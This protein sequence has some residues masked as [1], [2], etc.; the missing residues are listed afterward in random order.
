MAIGEPAPAHAQ[1]VRW[2][3]SGGDVAYPTNFTTLMAPKF[4]NEMAN[5]KFIRT[6][7]AS[8]T[9]DGYLSSNDWS[10]FNAKQAT[11]GYTPATNTLAGILAAMGYTPPTNNNA[12][13]VLALSFSPATNTFAGIA[14]ALG[15]TP[16]T[17]TSAG[18]VSAL[19]FQPATNTLAGILAAMGYTPPTNNNSGIVLALGFNPATNSLAGIAAALGYT[20]MTNTAAAITAALGYTP[21]PGNTTLSNLFNTGAFTNAL[22]AGSGVTF[23]TNASGIITISAAAGSGG[24]ADS[25]NPNPQLNGLWQQRLGASYWMVASTNNNGNMQILGPSHMRFDPLVGGGLRLGGTFGVFANSMTVSNNLILQGTVTGTAA[26]PE[27]ALSLSDNTTGNASTVKH[28]FAPKLSGSVVDVLSGLGTWVKGKMYHTNGQVAVS[29]DNE[30]QGIDLKDETG[31]TAMFVSEGLRLLYDDNGSPSIDFAQGR[32]LYETP[33]GIR[34]DWINRSLGGTWTVNALNVSGA[35][36]A[37]SIATPSLVATNFSVHTLE[38]A[39]NLF[40][41]TL[42]QLGRSSTITTSTNIGL[43]GLSNLPTGSNTA[44]GILNIRSA[45]P[46]VTLTNPPGWGPSD[47]VRTRSI[48][49]GVVCVEVQPGV[50]TNMVILH[51]PTL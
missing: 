37:D 27:V 24:A 28:G 12:G 25:I 26:I 4:A 43:T 30:D 9:V 19:K 41:G 46:G 15:Y 50:Y 3:S 10:A 38:F 39:T 6:N 34:L 17:N 5:K 42:F 45:W 11:L 21:M 36:S 13:I 47:G 35:I 49:N 1:S 22:A 33:F 51:H 31:T 40:S 23:V 32:L 2:D 7:A 48:T 20:P 8:A 44:Y 29:T 18:L 14:A 16:A